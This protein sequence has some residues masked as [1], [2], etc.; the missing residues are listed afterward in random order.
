MVSEVE[1]QVLAPAR[2]LS[3]CPPF[4]WSQSISGAKRTVFNLVACDNEFEAAFA[5]FLEHAPDVAAFAKLPMRFAFSIEY[6]D[7]SGNLRL[8]HPDWVARADDGVMYLMETKG[9]VGAEVAQKDRAATIW[10]ENATALAGITWRYRRVDQVEL[11]KLGPKHLS[12]LV[13]MLV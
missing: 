3:T 4:P 12:D 6:L 7:D 11:E 8:Y 10:C 2:P 13:A 9:Y 1:P 5:R